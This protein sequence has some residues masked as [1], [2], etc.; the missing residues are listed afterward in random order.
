[1]SK[2]AGSRRGWIVRSHIV[3]RGN[4]CELGRWVLKGGGWCASEY[5]R[6]QMEVDCEISYRYKRGTSANEN[7][8]PRRGVDCEISHQLERKMKP[9]L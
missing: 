1:M 3:W 5:A 9:C 7:T 6:P 8:R 4:E 2:D